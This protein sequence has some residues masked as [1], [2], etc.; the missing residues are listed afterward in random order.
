MKY[1]DEQLFEEY[2]EKSL[3]DTER[4]K[5]FELALKTR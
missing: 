3:E 2:K 4:M 1:V 5:K